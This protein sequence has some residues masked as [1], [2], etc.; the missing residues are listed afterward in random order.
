MSE[1]VICCLG[2]QETNSIW[3]RNQQSEW[4]LLR[5]V[6]YVKEKQLKHKFGIQVEFFFCKRTSIVSI[7]KCELISFLAGQER[8][9]AITSA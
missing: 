2:L 8:Y 9:R 4:N 1:K 6:L 7:F 3:K 5:G